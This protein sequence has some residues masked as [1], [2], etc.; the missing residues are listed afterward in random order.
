MKK[1]LIVDDEEPI[2]RVLSKYLAGNGTTISTATEYHAAK[3]ELIRNRYDLAILDLKI[4]HNTRHSGLELLSYIKKEYPLT[5][6]II[7]T[8]FGSEKTEKDAYDH[9]A[10][11]YLEKPF[12]FP[13]L[14]TKLKEIG[15][16]PHYEPQ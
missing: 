5:K 4:D 9:G 3:F 7:M 6:V 15:I 11:Y 8:G 14:T 10:Y 12:D 16:H 2:L 13:S 1:I